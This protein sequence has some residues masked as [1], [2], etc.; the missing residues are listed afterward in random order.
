[1]ARLR[2]P[3]C[4]YNLKIPS[5]IVQALVQ[6]RCCSR[7]FTLERVGQTYAVSLL[8]ELPEGSA[9]PS[10]PAAFRPAGAPLLRDLALTSPH[11]CQQC[12]QE[13]HLATGVPK[14]TIVCPACR[15]RTSV[16]A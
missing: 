7:R 9:P 11:H 2:C 12:K 16:Y 13:I 14:T 4:G 15:N 10:P 5:Y 6:C 3:H 8:T 1:M